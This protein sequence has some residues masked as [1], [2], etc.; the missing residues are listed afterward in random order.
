MGAKKD[1]K[2]KRVPRIIRILEKEYPGART[3]LR[4]ATPL[5]LLT[6]APSAPP[7][8]RPMKSAKSWTSAMKG[9][10]GRRG[11]GRLLE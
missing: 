9:W 11:R 5:E 6:A 7:K 8:S 3:A 4:F 2:N 1:E 10:L